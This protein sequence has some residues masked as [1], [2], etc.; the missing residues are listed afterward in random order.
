MP[1]AAILGMWF[2]HHAGDERLAQLD[3]AVSFDTKRPVSIRQMFAILSM[4]GIAGIVI[5]V[6]VGWELAVLS[7]H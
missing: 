7:V 4:L 2:A 3:E 6:A 1:L 5:A